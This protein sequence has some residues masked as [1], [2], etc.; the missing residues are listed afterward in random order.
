MRGAVGQA[1]STTSGSRLPRLLFGEPKARDGADEAPVPAGEAAFFW[2]LVPSPRGY[3]VA[4]H[5]SPDPI[6]R[7]GAIVLDGIEYR[8]AIIAR[9]PFLDGRQCAYLER[10]T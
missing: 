4:E 5:R 9:S 2:L 1:I 8:V 6:V 7:G 3:A 10:A